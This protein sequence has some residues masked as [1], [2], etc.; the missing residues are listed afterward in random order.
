MYKVYDR[1]HNVVACFRLLEEA[2]KYKEA[3]GRSDWY[4]PSRKSTPRQRAAVEWCQSIFEQLNN[5]Q[6]FKGNINL[7]DDCSNYLSVY[8]DGA[9]TIMEDAMSGFPFEKYGY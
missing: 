3:L 8:L 2:R 7:F 4:I 1:T 6:P 5:P 9:K